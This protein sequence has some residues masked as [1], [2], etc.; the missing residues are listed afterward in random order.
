[1]ETDDA[2]KSAVV[3]P[4]Q[5]PLFLGRSNETLEETPRLLRK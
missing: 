1:M 2:V 4:I 5:E 3:L